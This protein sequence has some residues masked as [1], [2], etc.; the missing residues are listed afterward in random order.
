MRNSLDHL[1]GDGQYAGRDV[2]TER[3]GSLEIE[4]ELE[5]GWPEDWQVGGLFAL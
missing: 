2:E 4:H 5:L 3:S 1:V